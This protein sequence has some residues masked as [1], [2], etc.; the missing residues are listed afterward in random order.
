M[1]A[2][3]WTRAL[4]AFCSCSTRARPAAT[5]RASTSTSIASNL[6]IGRAKEP[7]RM[8]MPRSPYK[9]PMT[10]PWALRMGAATTA[11]TLATLMLEV[12]TCQSVRLSW[13]S[14]SRMWALGRH[15]SLSTPGLVHSARLLHSRPSWSSTRQPSR[16]T[17]S[18]TARAAR[19]RNSLELVASWSTSIAAC[20]QRIR[21]SD[22]IPAAPM[23][24][25]RDDMGVGRGKREPGGAVRSVRLCRASSSSGAGAVCGVWARKL[26]LSRRNS[27]G[28][29]P[30]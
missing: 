3:S 2:S 26:H 28:N 25:A 6:L 18:T 24:W 27:A 22:A 11:A 9:A 10:S 13:R 14:W 20:N 4:M 15:W 16:L 12:G 17:S 23:E 1:A 21:S 30:V 7:E 8:P 19:G 5:P 29:G